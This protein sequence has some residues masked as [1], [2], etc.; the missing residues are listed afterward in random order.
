[1]DLQ[2]GVKP[3]SPRERQIIELLVGGLTQKEV[4]CQLGISPRTVSGYLERVQAK[5]GQTTILA[6]V[7]FVMRGSVLGDG[8]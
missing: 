1:M 4:A 3:L 6:A 5:T 2:T 8:G 7:V